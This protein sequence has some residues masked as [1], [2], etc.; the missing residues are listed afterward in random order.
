ML[1]IGETRAEVQNMLTD[2][3]QATGRIGLKLHMGE[4]KILSN[5]EHSLG[6]L[7][8]PIVK[9]LNVI[10]EVLAF[11]CKLTYLGRLVSFADFQD[12]EIKHRVAR[13]WA[14]FAKHKGQLCNKHYPLQSRLRSFGAAVSS[15]VLYGS[16]C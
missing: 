3:A 15:M 7:R 4:T 12:T 11:D 1:I 9:L 10:V 14:A 6:V 13:G 8:Q 5:I 16:G 2:R